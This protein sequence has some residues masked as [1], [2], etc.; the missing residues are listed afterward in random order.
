MR[1]KIPTHIDLEKLSSFSFVLLLLIN[2]RFVFHA[3]NY[4]LMTC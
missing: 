3:T 2:V 1:L 4:S